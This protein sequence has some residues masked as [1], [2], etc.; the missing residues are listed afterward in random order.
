MP[1]AIIP[2]SL[3]QGLTT[4]DAMSV[5]VA[6]GISTATTSGLN[7]PNARGRAALLVPRVRAPANAFKRARLVEQYETWQ[8]ASGRWNVISS[9]VHSM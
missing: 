6:V 8:G 2:T 3:R 7:V 1:R 4:S 9:L 5:G